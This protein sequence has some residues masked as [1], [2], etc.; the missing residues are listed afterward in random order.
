MKATKN[1][2]DFRII[3][4]HLKLSIKYKNIFF[5]FYKLLFFFIISLNL[6]FTSNTYIFDLLISMKE[7]I[8]SMKRTKTFNE[9]HHIFNE[10]S[11]YSMKTNIQNLRRY[12]LIYN[13][14]NAH[15]W[16]FYIGSNESKL[17]Y[18]IL[19]KDVLQT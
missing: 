9:D 11:V 18:A 12:E 14:K 7:I 10:R 6:T 15:I 3:E 2:N 4:I 8:Y 16:N 13:V 17:K 5:I 19:I 1:F